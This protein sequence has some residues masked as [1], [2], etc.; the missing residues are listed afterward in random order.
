MELG[1]NC[2]RIGNKTYQGRQNRFQIG[3]GGGGGGGG[4]HVTLESIF[5][6]HGSPPRKNFEF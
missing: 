6:H 3:K 1:P 5:G 2:Y 4:G